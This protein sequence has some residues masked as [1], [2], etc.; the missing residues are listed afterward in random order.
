MN[1][2][3]NII[4]WI[5]TIWLALAMLAS[6]IQQIFTIGG[7][8]EIMAHLGFPVYFSMIIGIW[9]LLGVTAILLPRLSL[10]K[11]WAYAGFCF[12]L[13]GAVLAHLTMGDNA[14]ELFAPAFLLVLTVISWYY[15]P[16]SR[17]IATVQAIS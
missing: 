10:L 7:F 15:R 8:V 4:Y 17:K 5:A 16:T 1:K 3:H 12:I 9:K 11:E 14:K 2:R 13:S 6:G